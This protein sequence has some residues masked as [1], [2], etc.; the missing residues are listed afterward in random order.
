[1]KILMYSERAGGWQRVGHNIGY[2]KLSNH[3]SPL[4]KS[5]V[6]YYCLSWKMVRCHLTIHYNDYDIIIAGVHS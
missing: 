3:H 4:L 6:D 5:N 1:M 2:Y